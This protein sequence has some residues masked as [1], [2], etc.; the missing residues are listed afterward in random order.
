MKKSQW[1]VAGMKSVATLDLSNRPRCYGLRATSK[2]LT[3]V[4]VVFNLRMV[5]FPETVQ[6]VPTSSF[7][8]WATI[9]RGRG[10]IGRVSNFSELR[11]DKIAFNRLHIA[12]AREG[13]GMK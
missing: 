6:S 11:A 7:I 12:S 9:S 4:G 3:R 5:W 10:E 1:E 13:R 2:D 8:H